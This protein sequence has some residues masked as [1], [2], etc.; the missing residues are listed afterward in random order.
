MTKTKNHIRLLQSLWK[1]PVFSLPRGENNIG[2]AQVNNTKL[3]ESKD[4]TIRVSFDKVQNAKGYAL[5]KVE[6]G[7]PVSFDVENRID[8]F[9]ESYGEGGYVVFNMPEYDANYDYYVI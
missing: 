7:A 8:I 6:K 4:G 3:I 9:Y 5:Y 2:N 1:N